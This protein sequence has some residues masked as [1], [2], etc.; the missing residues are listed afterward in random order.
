MKPRKRY[1]ATLVTGLSLLAVLGGSLHYA[2]GRI[3]RRRLEDR[4]DQL[5]SDL[6]S[7]QKRS[8]ENAPSAVSSAGENP[9]RPS[10]GVDERPVC[11]P[12]VLGRGRSRNW[13]Y[14]DV[15]Y[16]DG[17]TYRYYV[18]QNPS[19]YEVKQFVATLSADSYEHAIYEN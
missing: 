17:T 10:G 8:A 5:E 7:M 16:P 15:R 18:R 9:P 4:L 14:L 12:R 6:A 19:R 11:R 2:A 1:F 3:Q 13:L